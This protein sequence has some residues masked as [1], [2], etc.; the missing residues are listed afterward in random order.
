MLR[1]EHLHEIAHSPA[2]RAEPAAHQ[3][4]PP[5]QPP[6]QL[7]LP[8]A[9]QPV[10]AAQPRHPGED[11]GLALV[12]AEAVSPAAESLPGYGE[13]DCCGEAL[14]VP[15]AERAGRAGAVCRLAV[16]QRGVRGEAG[17]G[18]SEEGAEDGAAG[19]VSAAKY[20]DGGAPVDGFEGGGGEAEGVAAG[21]PCGDGQVVQARAHD[22]AQSE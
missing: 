11:G 1:L 8:H 9:A 3:H 15:R 19:F 2:G 7:L 14:A 18:G 21:L 10:D 6:G 20:E 16:G 17:Q 4:H 12:P 22:E 5:R 13:D